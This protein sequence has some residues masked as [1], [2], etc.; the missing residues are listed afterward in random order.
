MNEQARTAYV[1]AQ[2]VRLHAQIT[3]MQANNLERDRKGQAA[4]FSGEMIEKVID[5][6]PVLRA[7]VCQ[8]FLL[9]NVGPDGK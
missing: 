1:M 3:M 2:A 7:D 4:A 5:D 6:Y 8:Q 9:G